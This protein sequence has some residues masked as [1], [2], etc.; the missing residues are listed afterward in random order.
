MERLATFDEFWPFYLSQH[1]NASSRAL[2]V[3]GTGL[4]IAVFLGALISGRYAMLFLL[5]VI[6]YL[7]AW[8]GH[9]VFEKNRPATFQYPLWSLR[10]DFKM[11]FLFV[12][13]KLSHHLR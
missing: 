11:F 2:H 1:K 7:P 5:P 6:G 9:Y 3:F 12:T 13:G 10:A 4:V 8:I